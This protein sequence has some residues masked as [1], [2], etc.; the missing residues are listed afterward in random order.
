MKEHAQNTLR[1][2]CPAQGQYKNTPDG[3]GG[4]DGDTGACDLFSLLGRHVTVLLFIDTS[5][6][7]RLH[8]LSLCGNKMEMCSCLQAY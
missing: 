8:V 7:L 5:I 3:V 4:E 1:A 6:P 2:H